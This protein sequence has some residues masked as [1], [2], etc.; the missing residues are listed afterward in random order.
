MKFSR[1]VF[2]VL[3]L[4]GITIVLIT[5]YATNDKQLS[6]SK[7]VINR[8]SELDSLF[9]YSSDLI[10]V[11]KSVYVFTPKGGGTGFSEGCVRGNIIYVFNGDVDIRNLPDYIT[12]VDV[13]DIDDY[14]NML[15][16]SELLTRI[17]MQ[18]N[19]SRYSVFVLRY[20]YPNYNCW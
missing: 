10:L 20:G 17:K 15:H 6:P 1:N 7:I 12:K 3:L 8:L 2:F 16:D 13:D 5:I 14:K 11:E 9:K 4:I 19:A 18:K